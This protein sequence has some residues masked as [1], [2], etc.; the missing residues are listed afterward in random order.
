MK[1]LLNCICILSLPFFCLSQNTDSLNI[2][3]EIFVKVD[4]SASFPGGI[5]AWGNEINKNLKYPKQAQR[6]G[7]EGRVFVQFIVEKDGTLTDVKVVKGIGGGCDV[8]AIRFVKNQPKWIPGKQNGKP[9]RQRMIQNIL[10]KFNNGSQLENEKIIQS[11]SNADSLKPISVQAIDLG[12]LIIDL[13]NYYY[14]V[15]GDSYLFHFAHPKTGVK[16]FIEDY[17]LSLTTHPKYLPSP[18]YTSLTFTVFEDGLLGDFILGEEV[19]KNDTLF[20]ET[21]LSLGSWEPSEDGKRNTFKLEL[22]TKDMVTDRDAR[23]PGDIQ[24]FNSYLKNNLRLPVTSQRI[25]EDGHVIVEFFVEM[26]GSITDTRILK[27]IGPAYDKEALRIVE[28]MPNWIPGIENGIPSR[29]R[30]EQRIIFD[31]NLKRKAIK[32]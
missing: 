14:Y 24:S 28:E 1:I 11:E 12:S 16:K 6:M 23:F 20:V 32:N 29:Q 18:I 4:E 30:V 2:G 9:I 21:L 19:N 8:E 10:F 15:I 5:H 31:I 26:D 22:R 25:F 27:G 13:D 7:I 17:A 3:D